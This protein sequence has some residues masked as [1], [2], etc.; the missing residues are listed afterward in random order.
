MAAAKAARRNAL[1]HNL[2]IPNEPFQDPLIGRRTGVPLNIKARKDS[3]GFENID[4]YFLYS[5]PEV[6]EEEEEENV[7]PN[8]Q[9]VEKDLVEKEN[10]NVH[11]VED[12]DVFE[13]V[14]NDHSPSGDDALLKKSYPEKMDLVDTPEQNTVSPNNTGTAI[15]NPA[16]RE[17]TPQLRGPI[18]K[19]LS[20][21]TGQS[22][23]GSE[24]DQVHAGDSLDGQYAKTSGKGVEESDTEIDVVND[25]PQLVIKEAHDEPSYKEKA[26]S[27]KKT[28]AVTKKH[29]IVADE[30][31]DE[32]II[33]ITGTEE[34]TFLTIGNLSRA[35]KT[36]AA[37]H[38]L[39]LSSQ[40]ES[41]VMSESFVL[42]G[43]KHKAMSPEFGSSSDNQDEPAT[44]GYKSRIPVL[45]KR[46]PSNKTALNRAAKGRKKTVNRDPESVMVSVVGQND[47]EEENT[48][49]TVTHKEEARPVQGR[50]TRGKAKNVEESHKQK[51]I[52]VGGRKSVS[53]VTHQMSRITRESKQKSENHNVDDEEFDKQKND[54]GIKKTPV[55]KGRPEKGNESRKKT[56]Q[57]ESVEVKQKNGGGTM[58]LRGRRTRGQ[59]KKEQ[60]GKVHEQNGEEEALQVAVDVVDD[61]DFERGNMELLGLENE[62][63]GND[64]RVSMALGEN[65]ADDVTKG[66][67]GKQGKGRRKDEEMNSKKDKSVVGIAAEL[68]KSQ[69]KDFV[70]HT[71][72][73]MSNVSITVSSSTESTKKSSNGVA[74]KRKK[75]SRVVA[76]CARK[77]R[78][79]KANSSKNSSKTNSYDS[80]E[81]S[82]D[83]KKQ[84]L[85]NEA[86]ETSTAKDSSRKD[87]KTNAGKTSRT[88]RA[89]RKSEA[90]KK[91]STTDDVNDKAD[92]NDSLQG[93]EK[94]SSS[95]DAPAE[96]MT[97]LKS[98][99][100]SGGSVRRSATGSRK[101]QMTTEKSHSA[102]S[103][104]DDESVQPAKQPNRKSLSAVSF[105]STPFVHGSPSM[106]AD[107]SPISL[108]FV[109]KNSS[110]KSTDGTFTPGSART[111]RSSVG[112]ASGSSVGGNS[113]VDPEEEV[114]TT[115][116]TSQ[117]DGTPDGQHTRR[118]KRTIVPPLQYWKNERI[119]YERRK[120]GGWCI[121]G[122]IKNPTPTPKYRK[123]RK[124]T[125]KLSVKKQTN[126]N[127]PD[128][129]E[130]EVDN[131]LEGFQE[132]L[133]PKGTVLNSDNNEEV[134]MDIFHTHGMLNFTN[135]SGKPPQENDPLLVH[136]YISRPLFGGGQ[137][138]LRPEA[139]KGK[140][141]VRQDTMGRVKVTVHKS[142]AILHTGS[143]FFIPQGN[144]Y[145]IENLRKTAAHLLF[146][147]I[148][149]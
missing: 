70:E 16:S 137:V 128:S 138:I 50:R 125:A 10:A 7:A 109:S 80:T 43:T 49:L 66:K 23:V 100:K 48:G 139:E 147:Q 69:N 28:P 21:I 30:S 135:P 104:A 129:S 62:K 14:A 3:F 116:G 46:Y 19:R 127:S 27:M 140:Q 24:G 34:D 91:S 82:V 141:F 36:N 88:K 103:D 57:I 54:D 47:V 74:T 148:K 142:S 6:E 115:N 4:D 64:G 39:P 56:E 37:V 119:D 92:I 149:G 101:R 13:K 71:A 20:F 61:D 96:P 65:E 84:R 114:T 33:D 146:V 111:I 42:E 95:L 17:P 38:K 124:Q 108:S 143:T 107:S 45:T 130:D 87:T 110:Y 145:N 126:A 83:A 76:P 60:D 131:D 2:H 5:D 144:S 9:K 22:P 117:P 58:E 44:K 12:V 18:S 67:R 98:I 93:A 136:K 89:G 81:L 75:V 51:R 63:T 15:K 79:G 106:L 133:N 73:S 35:A 31:G 123:K 122:I 25:D 32:E 86:N 134:A 94:D 55:H 68:I 72:Q 102:G 121:K 53:S 1:L 40:A 132:I 90:E 118:S 29:S 112:S 105:A 97:A 78:G 113:E 41:F 8:T 59:R 99:L 52:K 26:K 120:S 77:R 11:P 85:L